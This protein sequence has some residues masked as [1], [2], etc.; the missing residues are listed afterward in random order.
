MRDAK[1]RSPSD[2]HIDFEPKKEII[3]KKHAKNKKSESFISNYT[4]CNKDSVVY[5]LYW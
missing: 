4:V 3:I 2:R 1:I 5:A